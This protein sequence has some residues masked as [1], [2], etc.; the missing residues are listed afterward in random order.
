[1]EK[2]L[3]FIISLF[4]LSISYVINQVL[5]LLNIR[6]QSLKLL[7]LYYH[8]IPKKYI[9]NFTWQLEKLNSFGTVV[10]P[11]SVNKTSKK[12]RYYSITFDDGLKS[13]LENAAPIIKQ[14]N[15]PYTIFFP[16]AYI[17]KYPKWD[18]VGDPVDTTEEIIDE[19]EIISLIGKN[20]KIGSHSVNHVNM[21]KIS[22]EQRYKEFN[23]SKQ[24]LNNLIGDKVN[25]FSFPYG[26]YD[27]ETLKIAR[28]IGYKFIFTSDPKLNYI[29]PG[30]DHFVLGR[31]P[32]EP[33]DSKLEFIVKILGG[34]NWVYGYIL[35]KR[36]L[37]KLVNKFT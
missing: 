30:I 20:I 24:F 10:L 2:R 28:E 13:V 32:V 11:D 29:E 26:A 17:G 34:Y 36:K 4:Y 21:T 5:N 27:D 3:K 15:I 19:Y 31:V 22:C 37:K 7:I 14:L 1:M 33:S 8:S 16:T 23:E 9:D 18:I 25:F 35:F 6:N 12:R